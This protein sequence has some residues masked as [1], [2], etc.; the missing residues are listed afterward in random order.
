MPP[1]ALRAW[2]QFITSLLFLRA[3]NGPALAEAHAKKCLSLL[4]RM[5]LEILKNP[6]AKKL[7]ELEA[8]RPTSLL[9]FIVDRILSDFTGTQPDLVDTYWEYFDL[10]VL[11]LFPITLK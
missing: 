3:R 4:R 7:E 6:K 1:D 10:L 5:H 9:V 2:H 11:N 8:V